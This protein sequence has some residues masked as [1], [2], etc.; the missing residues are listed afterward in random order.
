MCLEERNTLRRAR[1]R[2]ASLTRRR[3]LARRRAV[4]SLNLDIAHSHFFLPSLR[5]TYSSAYFT[6]LPL[7]GSG[8]RKLRISAATWPTCCLSIPLIT[9]SVGLGVAIAIPCGIG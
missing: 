3:T 8:G 5:K 2:A 9:I 7:Y 4:R 1:P 6:P